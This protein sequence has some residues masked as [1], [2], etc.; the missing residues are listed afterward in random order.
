MFASAVSHRMIA[1]HVV[2]GFGGTAFAFATQASAWQGVAA[3]QSASVVHASSETTGLHSAHPQS[4]MGIRVSPGVG[5]LFGGAVELAE[6]SDSS[7]ETL[8]GASVEVGAATF[9]EPPQAMTTSAPHAAA[10][11][12]AMKR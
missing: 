6:A 11:I 12:M 2:P 9:C 3:A 10:T 8:V 7:A 4:G 1:V 5:P